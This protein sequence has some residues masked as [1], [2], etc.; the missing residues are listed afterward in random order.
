M[1]EDLSVAGEQEKEYLWGRREGVV[2]GATLSTM[3]HR[4]RER[5][6]S[7]LDRWDKVL[8][9][10]LGASAFVKVF[11][12]DTVTWL[13]IPFGLLASCSLI[14]DF[15]ER[16]RQHSQLASAFKGLEADVEAKG[17]R[18]FTEDD[19]DAWAARLRRI[20]ADEPATYNIVV[21]LCQNEIARARG[22]RKD[23]TSIG[24][25]EYW[26][27]HLWLHANSDVKPISDSTEAAAK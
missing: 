9:L 8:T 22:E 3:Y 21:R 16:A 15:A 20:E 4:R 19:V 11:G 18:G 25:L 7:L 27:A 5:F 1:S 2:Y 24:R 12:D 14:F 26:T 17:E 6:F 10:V 23:V 13:G